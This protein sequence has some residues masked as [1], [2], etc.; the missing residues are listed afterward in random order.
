MGALENKCLEAFDINFQQPDV[1]KP[2][3]A[4][5]LSSVMQGTRTTAGIVRA[6]IARVCAS[7]YACR[8]MDRIR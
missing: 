8:T 2:C 3:I 5:K 6:S 1:L 4:T 7:Q